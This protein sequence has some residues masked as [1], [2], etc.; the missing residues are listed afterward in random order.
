MHTLLGSS[1]ELDSADLYSLQSLTFKT[2]ILWY[3]RGI[4]FSSGFSVLSVSILQGS[5]SCYQSV[6]PLHLLLSWADLTR[7]PGFKWDP[8]SCYWH[9]LLIS[10]FFILHLQLC[11]LFA[12]QTQHSLNNPISPC[13]VVSFLV[14]IPTDDNTVH[15]V[16]LTK[17]WGSILESSFSLTNHIQSICKYFK[18]L[19]PSVCLCYAWSH[20][21]ELLQ[22]S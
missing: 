11:V 9:T 18:I 6:F 13:K 12:L 8:Y 3:F 7:P 15:L 21:L 5:A 22:A 14:F 20:L 10:T 17:K 1:V 19:S 16:F 4:S 2:W